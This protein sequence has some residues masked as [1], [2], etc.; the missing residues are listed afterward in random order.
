MNIPADLKYAKSDEWVR[1]DANADTATAGISDYAQTQLSDIVFVELPN[2]GT[3]L[4]QGESFGSVESVKAA[5]DVYIPIRGEI[6]EVNEELADSP[7]LVNQDP[8]GKAWMIK[9]KVTNAGELAGLMDAAAYQKY[10]D[11]RAH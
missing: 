6:T 5:S 11:E 10:C 9:F 1:V 8:Y 4:K 2:V 3:S 7:E